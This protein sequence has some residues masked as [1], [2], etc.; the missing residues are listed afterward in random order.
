M[1][2]RDF[3]QSAASLAAMSVIGNMTNSCGHPSGL[4]R[5][6]GKTGYEV[7]PVGYGGIVSMN[8]GQEASDRYVSWAIDRGIN[9]FDVA[10]SYGDAEEKLGNS[11]KAYR[12]NSYL[13]CKTTKRLSKEAEPEFEQSFDHLHTD[14]FDVYQMHSLSKQEDIDQ[15]FGPGGVMEMM[16]K[17]K[18]DG[19]VRKLGLT[20]HS[21]EIALKAM[22]LYDFDTVL[23][24]VN[25]MM[26][27]KT[28]MATTLCN[29]A[30][31]RK[32]GL[33]AMKSLV[34]RRWFDQSEDR[35]DYGKSWC[36]PIPT[37]NK[38]LGVAAI[39][40]AFRLGA[41]IIIPPGNFKSFSFAVDHIEEII[42]Q[43]VTTVETA[44]LENEFAM[45][46]EYPFF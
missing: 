7:F 31:K 39:K 8:D 38:A 23:F 5:K 46:K 6:L 41:D 12:K 21:E 4:R 45:V 22:A 34:L 11:L 9:Y 28:G 16:V 32:M 27:M 20:A 24:P 19:R 26:N 29:D 10:P 1:K 3:I 35:G 25:W 43:P 2:R 33:L 13:A 18:R 40:Y 37:E 42:T 44:L 17:A 15:A 36:K 30:K 14:Y